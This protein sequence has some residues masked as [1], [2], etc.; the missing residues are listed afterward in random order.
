MARSPRERSKANPGFPLDLL[1]CSLQPR[2]VS[3]YAVVCLAPELCV[4][5]AFRVEIERLRRV[6]DITTGEGFPEHATQRAATDKIVRERHAAD[7][8]MRD[9][10][11]RREPTTRL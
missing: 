5:V 11:V 2:E 8:L 1:M 3:V 10:Q 6:G 7:K 4:L 9:R